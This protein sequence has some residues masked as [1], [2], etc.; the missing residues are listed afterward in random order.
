MPFVPFGEYRPDVADYQS[1]YATFLANALPRGDGYG[2]FPDFSA[3][4]AALPAACRGFF[5]AIRSDGSIAIFAATATRLYQLNN[6]NFVWTD[7]SKGG[8]GYPALSASDN[9]QFAQFNN[10]VSAAQANV[11]P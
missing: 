3:Y 11:P 9:W 4:S 6:I 1:Q 10:F 7:V 5:K 8:V 2:P